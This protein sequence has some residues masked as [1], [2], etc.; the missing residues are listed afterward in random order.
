MTYDNDFNRSET[1]QLAR[2]I[3][4]DYPYSDAAIDAM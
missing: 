1:N 2:G 3:I 4:R